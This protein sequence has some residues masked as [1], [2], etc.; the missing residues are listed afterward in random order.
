M[1]NVRAI[2]VIHHLSELAD[3]IRHEPAD[4][5]EDSDSV[6]LI[7]KQGLSIQFDS[8]KEYDELIR[9]FQS[10]VLYEKLRIDGRKS[11]LSNRLD[12]LIGW[13]R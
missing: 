8:D 6:A 9:F 7:V 11:N 2:T 12:R 5:V 1:L 10:N 4:L 13:I 3:N